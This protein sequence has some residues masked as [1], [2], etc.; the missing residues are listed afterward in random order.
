M[1]PS[2]LTHARIVDAAARVADRGGLAQV[3]MRN[4]GK[5]LGVEAMSL[6]HHVKGKDALLDALVEWLFARMERPDP[7]APWRAAMTA[8]ARSA[9]AVLSRHSWGLGLLESRRSPGPAALG[10]HDAVLGCLRHNGFP[11]ALAA[12]AFSVLDAYVFGFVLTELNLPFDAGQGAEEYVAGIDLLADRYPHLAEMAAA[13]IAGG[14]Y[15]YGDE[16]ERG[17]ELVLDSLET[18]LNGLR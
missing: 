9:R 2:R 3:S 15:S 6:Y 4:V 8:R 10:Y 5:E 14:R 11:V 18:R 16:F 1:V 13:Q 17:L 12:S 7:R